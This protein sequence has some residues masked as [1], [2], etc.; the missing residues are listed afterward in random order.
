MGTLEEMERKVEGTHM[1]FLRQITG[2]RARSI[3][4]RTWEKPGLEVVQEAA[5]TQS[6]MTYIGIRHATVVQWV[7]LRPIFEVYKG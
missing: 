6:D 7:D 3:S 5:V 1:G 2:K 4:D